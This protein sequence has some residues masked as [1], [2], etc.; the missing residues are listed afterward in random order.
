MITQ[1]YQLYVERT[2]ARKNMA[3]YYAMS[4]EP[5]LFGETSL[6]RRWGRIGSGG[7][8]MVHHFAREE[9]AVS[10]FLH[11]VRKRR[12]RGY[13]PKPYIRQDASGDI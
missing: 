8:R 5:T 7:Q 12:A 4:I 2:D 3:R 11:L 9:E 1:P 10:L 13:K 6:V